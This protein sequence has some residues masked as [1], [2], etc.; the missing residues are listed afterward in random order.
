M[1][2]SAWCLT[3][4]FSCFFLASAVLRGTDSRQH[5]KATTSACS[6]IRLLSNWLCPTWSLSM[7][8]KYG[9]Q[10]SR[11]LSAQKQKFLSAPDHIKSST[12]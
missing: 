3:W 1:E 8:C 9:F 2:C 12:V 10:T 6:V 4:L 11:F 7:P 5:C